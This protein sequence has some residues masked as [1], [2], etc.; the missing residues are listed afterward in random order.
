M[1]SLIWSKYTVQN[2]QR[3]NKKFEGGGRKLKNKKQTKPSNR[4]AKLHEQSYMKTG[5]G[6][7]ENKRKRESSQRK[8]VL[9]NVKTAFVCVLVCVHQSVC[10]PVHVCTSPCVHQ[11]VCAQATVDMWWSENSLRESVL[12]LTTWVWWTRPWGLEMDNFTHKAIY[13]A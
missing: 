5:F 10:A 1:G 2:S 8:Y 11:S 9:F 7:F 4:K 6:L 12:P 13:L 3:S